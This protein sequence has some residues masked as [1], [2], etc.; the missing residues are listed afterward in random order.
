[1]GSYLI[2]TYLEIILNS[3]WG[4]IFLV[5]MLRGIWF[6]IHRDRWL[7]VWVGLELNLICFIPFIIQGDKISGEPSVKYFL[8][9]A[10]AS[11]LLLFRGVSVVNYIRGIKVLILISLLLK[12]GAA[13]FYIWYLWVG[14]SLR[15]IQ[16]LVLRTTQKIAPLVLLFFRGLRKGVEILIYLRIIR[17]GLIGGVGGIN[18]VS[19]RKLL[20]FSSLNHIGWILIPLVSER[21]FWFTYFLFYCLILSIVV[22]ILHILKL[23][24]LNQIFSVRVSRVSKLT[25][26]TSFFSLGGLPP[27]LGFF[28]KLI[29][30]ERSVGSL[31]VLNLSFII[32]RSVVILFY[33]LRASLRVLILSHQQIRLNFI[34]Y[35]KISTIFILSITL[36]GG[37]IRS[38]LFQRFLQ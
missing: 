33:Y 17:N 8:V 20:I 27:L 36:L 22:W 2:D 11:F 10:C 21:E 37:W 35:N 32:V 4:F 15:W 16:F 31:I 5:G 23:Y 34:F 26:I 12:L 38:L 13:P 1:M 29:V 18:E 24:Y 30:I 28:P 19:L 25:L 3:F 6:S 7:G 9:Q 14:R